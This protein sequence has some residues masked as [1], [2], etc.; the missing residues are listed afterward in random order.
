MGAG[1]GGGVG[2][3][4]CGTRGVPG[5]CGLSCGGRGWCGCGTR[6]SRRS[7]PRH[8]ACNPGAGGGGFGALGQGWE[9]DGQGLGG[10]FGAGGERGGAGGVGKA[11]FSVGGL[12]GGKGR[13]GWGGRGGFVRVG[14][15]RVNCGT[16]GGGVSWG[17]PWRSTPRA[18]SADLEHKKHHMKKEKHM[19]VFLRRQELFQ[20]TKDRQSYQKWIG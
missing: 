7:G 8:G 1:R 10:G 20:A 15:A 4:G 14:K 11:S 17:L 16:V 18:G 6:G 5:F 19:K 2:A 9:M 3:G 13:G 12:G